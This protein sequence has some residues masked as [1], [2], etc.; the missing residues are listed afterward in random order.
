MWRLVRPRRTIWPSRDGWWCL[1][2][3]VALGVAAMATGNNLLYLLSALLLAMVVVSGMLSEVVMRGVR[4]D[5]VIPEDIHAGSATLLGA[6][7]RNGKRRLPSYVL[8]IE[9]V[10]RGRVE[11]ALEVARLAAG[12]ERLLTWETTLPR[13]GRQRLPG[14]RITTRFP[15][16]IFLK[17]SRVVPGTEVIVFPA[18]RPVAPHLARW[19]TG[20]GRTGARRRGRG[21]DLYNLRHYR[22]GDDPRLIHWR[23]TAKTGSLTVREFEAEATIDTRIVLERTGSDARRVEE[24]LS[25]AASLAVR[26]GRAGATVELTGVAGVVPAARGRSQERRILTALALYDPEAPRVREAVPR[27]AESSGL[28]EIRIGVG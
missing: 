8:R 3:A 19:S 10:S 9:V 24:A 17:A 11:R 27:L 26:L 1:A 14:L 13:R 4:A 28:R 21:G 18:L 7:L 2:L 22:A 6:S 23:S 25:G 16:G 12:A 15:F 5:M 20:G